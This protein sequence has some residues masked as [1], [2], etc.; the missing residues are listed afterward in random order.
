RIADWL[1]RLVRIPS[2]NPAQAGPRSGE[3]GE[4]RITD[5]VAEWLRELGGE[6]RREEVLPGRRNVYAIWEGTGSGWA[7]VDTHVDTVGVEVMTG[8]PFSGDVV[9]GR[10]HGRGAVDTKATLAVV[11]ALLEELQ[12]D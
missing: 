6:V 4:S 11:L 8:D 1:S 3:G 12:A 5:A 7:A 10:V 9:N 2:V